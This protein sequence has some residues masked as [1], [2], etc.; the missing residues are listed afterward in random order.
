VTRPS[1]QF[2]LG[3]TAALM[4]A[5]LLSFLI[6][7]EAGRRPAE[8]GALTAWMNDHPA[9]WVAAN[10]IAEVALD[11][12]LPQRFTL[13]RAAYAHASRLAPRRPTPRMSFVR[14]GLFHWYELAKPD[15]EAV[16]TAAAPLLADPQV[17]S[18]MH[19]PL[20]ELTGDFGYLR[21]NA[22][23]S[24]R[25]LTWLRDTAATHGLFDE[26]REVR[27]AIDRARLRAFEADRERLSPPALIALLPPRLTRGDEPLVRRVLREL[28]QRPLDAGN[29]AS[30]RNRADDLVR[31]AVRHGLRP[32]EGIEALI[33]TA[34]I[35]PVTR[36]R[37]ALA[38]GRTEAA[39]NIELTAAAPSE[40]W[41]AYYL[42]RAEFEAA[43]GDAAMAELYRKRAAS[44]ER[45]AGWRGTCGRNEIC[46]HAATTID[47]ARAGAPIVIELQNTQSDEVPPYVEIYVE[48]TRVAEGPVG[49]P[50]IASALGTRRFTV[51]APVAG[52]NRVEVRLINPWTRNRIQRRVRL[53]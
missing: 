48:D 53:S 45:A 21:R 41:A 30:V 12:T 34:S 44:I 20:W 23:D 26:Y 28:Q 3:F 32:L 7:S 9:D 38:L 36:A 15:R 10:A 31:F 50:V 25:A 37:L 29:A 24:E 17:F 42:E 14:G 22:P 46:K 19:R 49:H 13:W 6:D 16:L 51:A 2:F 11:S 33:E 4:A 18:A 43:R 47:A 27:D 1:R 40:E 5:L 35:N 8:V 39:S 52:P